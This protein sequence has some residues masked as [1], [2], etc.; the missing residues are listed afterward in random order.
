M[1]ICATSNRI[2]RCKRGTRTEFGRT[3]YGALLY[4]TRFRFK[5]AI[6]KILCSGGLKHLLQIIRIK[7][8]KSKVFHSSVLDGVEQQLW[9]LTVILE[10]GH[11]YYWELVLPK[12]IKFL[13]I[14]FVL[15]VIRIEAEKERVLICLFLVDKSE[16]YWVLYS[17]LSPAI[18]TT[19]SMCSKKY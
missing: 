3:D 14:N 6:S 8:S 15:T 2:R 9:G 16:N 11:Q 7:G 17:F 4:P 10:S 13:S 18:N 19:G 1:F 12:N 5:S